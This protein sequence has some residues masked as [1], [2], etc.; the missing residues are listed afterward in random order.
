MSG[1]WKKGYLD[2]S[3]YTGTDDAVEKGKASWR[4][5]KN[6]DMVSASVFTGQNTIGIFSSKP[7]N[8]WQ[9]DTFE[10]QVMG[11]EKSIL[12]AR[13]ICVQLESDDTFYSVSDGGHYLTVVLNDMNHPADSV[14][15]QCFCMPA[16]S[17]GSW[18]VLEVDP[19][20]YEMKT[21]V[22]FSSRKV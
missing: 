14:N 12:V 17:T 20:S 4:K 15:T 16:E 13:R 8:F 1:F 21:K 2:G 19:R 7:R 6:T 11:S 3:S 10:C 22:Y 9:S 18:L 5:S